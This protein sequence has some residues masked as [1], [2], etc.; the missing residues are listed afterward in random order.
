MFRE[1][2]GRW[3]LSPREEA[4]SEATGYSLRTRRQSLKESTALECTLEKKRLMEYEITL[5]A[6][7]RAGVDEAL[8]LREPLSM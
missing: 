2:K 8:D 6:A 1:D 4:Q 3:R 7:R 5:D